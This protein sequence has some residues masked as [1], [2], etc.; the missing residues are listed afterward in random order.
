MDIRSAKALGGFPI[1]RE[2]FEGEPVESVQAIWGSKPY[3]SLIILR[4]GSY[5]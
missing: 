2:D 3:K 4:E 1:V 5:V